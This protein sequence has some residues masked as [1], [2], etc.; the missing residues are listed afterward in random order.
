VNVPEQPEEFIVEFLPRSFAALTSAAESAQTAPGARPA[1]G[2]R[3]ARPPAAVGVVARVVGAGEWTLRILAG[4]LQVEPGVVGDVALS[5]TLLARDFVP[6]VVEPLRRSLSQTGGAPPAVPAGS[7][8]TRL[9]RWDE[10]T[11][12]L[13]SQQTGRILVR[14]DDSGTSRNVSLAPGA[15]PYALD[16]AE[17]TIDCQLSHLLDLQAKRG[18]PLDLFYSGQI[19]ITGD[20]QIAL[21]MAGLF[22]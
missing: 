22:L 5:A 17:C 9:G 13:L 3:A 7:L 6:L 15:Q 19:R 10:E 21:A 11:V 18:S 16:N 8:W 12:Q 20:A 14:V 2:R 4:R 1:P